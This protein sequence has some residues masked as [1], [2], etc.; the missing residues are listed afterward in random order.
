MPWI[1]N[2]LPHSQSVLDA[3]GNQ[4]SFGPRKKTYVKPELMSVYVWNLIREKKLINRAGDPVPRPAPAPAKPA[5]KPP[6]KPAV[7]RV[8]EGSRSTKTDTSS[9]HHQTRV[10]VTSESSGTG[11]AKKT[12]KAEKKQP[13]IQKKA[14]T[15]GNQDTKIEADAEEKPR[16]RRKRTFKKKG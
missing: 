13:D 8:D 4:V 14:D 1:Y 15:Q 12:P 11:S 3:K 9:S 5:V 7:A 6:A 16:K 10:K 2:P